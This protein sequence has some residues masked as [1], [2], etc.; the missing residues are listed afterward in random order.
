[1]ISIMIIAACMA[2]VVVFAYEVEGTHLQRMEVL[3]AK[4]QSA[5]L[6]SGCPC[7]IRV[8]AFNQQG[9]PL[10]GV[11]VTLSGSSGASAEV[12]GH[13]GIATFTVVPVFVNHLRYDMITVHATYQPPSGIGAPPPPETISTTFEVLQ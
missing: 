6:L 9:T 11:G 7:P 8:I 2:I 5:T 1:M 4:G 10:S 3:D 12:T 13:L